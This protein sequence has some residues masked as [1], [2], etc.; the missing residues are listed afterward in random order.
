M[1]LH[2]GPISP[3]VR[4]VMITA[5]ETSLVDR[6]TLVRSLVA[7]NKANQEVMADN[8]LSKI[9]TL[10]LD[11]GTALFDSDVICEYLDGLHAGPRLFPADGEARWTTLRWNALASGFI[12]ALVLWRNERMR[13]DGHQSLPTL[14]AYA[15]KTDATLAW[16]ERE[17]GDFAARPLSIGHVAL[18]CALGYLDLRFDDLGWRQGRPRTSA[19]MSLF[20]LRP[21]AVATQADVADKLLPPSPNP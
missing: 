20:M 3:F 7:M 16:I 6:I 12:D 2:W 4:K 10:V 17:I 18:G 21:S 1:K 14:Q 9:P 19:W 8:P 5:H 15:E 11:D 13:P